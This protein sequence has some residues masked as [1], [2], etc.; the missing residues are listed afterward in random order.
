MDRPPTSPP[1][2]PPRRPTIVFTNSG[3]A[4]PSYRTFA[5]PVLDPGEINA[6]LTATSLSNDLAADREDRSRYTEETTTTITTTVKQERSKTRDRIRKVKRTF[7][8]S[9]ETL[10]KDFYDDDDEDVRENSDSTLNPE[11]DHNLGLSRSRSREERSRITLVGAAESKDRQYGVLK[12]EL[13]AKH[14][15]KRGFYTIYA[16]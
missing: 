5:L 9:S 15:G 13:I 12:I 8:R 6:R 3:T 4:S 1:P 16:G 2:P 14:W 10:V 11:E 7:S